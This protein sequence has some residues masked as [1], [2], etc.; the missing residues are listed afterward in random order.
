MQVH[1]CSFSAAGLRSA[2][3]PAH[4]PLVSRC[5]PR[6][7]TRCG[8]WPEQQGAASFVD[9]RKLMAA[10]GV[11]IPLLQMGNSP[12]SAEEIFLEK[13]LPAGDATITNKVGHYIRIL[14]PAVS[15]LFL[16]A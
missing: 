6:L 11:S 5:S 7:D 1:Q 14:A 4:V 16:G 12:A 15:N 9:R 2:Q 3:H 8:A 10:V 13:D